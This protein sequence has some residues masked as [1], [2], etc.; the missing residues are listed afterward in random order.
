MSSGISG[1]GEKMGG[2]ASVIADITSEW[3]WM[4]K[5]LPEAYS[6]SASG[7]IDAVKKQWAQDIQSLGNMIKTA[8]PGLFGFIDDLDRRM[9]DPVE[10]PY[11]IMIQGLV[12][13]IKGMGDYLKVAWAKATAL[14]KIDVPDMGK[15]MS[16]ESIES[17][18]D[19]MYAGLNQ[20][21]EKYFDLQK[22][23]IEQDTDLWIKNAVNIARVKNL[24]VSYVLDL[25][26][27]YKEEQNALMEIDK[28][29]FSDRIVDGFKA[30]GIQIK[31]EIKT[32]GERAHEFV[33][34]MAGTLENG[35]MN[36][37]QDMQNWAAQ[38]KATLREIYFEALRLAFFQPAAQGLANAFAGVGSSIVGGLMGGSG[39]NF[40]Q[41]SSPPKAY[42]EGGI[43]WTPQLATVAEKGP[44]LITPLSKIGEMGNVEFHLHND[45]SP[46][47]I[48]NKTQYMMS[49]K[50]IIDVT[51]NAL[52]RSPK[53]RHA[54]SQA[55]G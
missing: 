54:M 20:R 10:N 49:D 34:G 23:R 30:A 48:T 14:P 41:I 19:K 44:E 6:E 16:D 22:K 38:F 45:G 47:E 11:A 8:V 42:A 46:M 40:N 43:A 33:M 17:A 9:Q 25:I 24:E 1:I 7:L 4:A 36:M 5:A 52:G 31:R 55:K 35:F 32:W 2:A 3:V 28:L 51:I 12:D 18:I 15:I 29:K 39:Y 53:L 50:R 13:K 26:A 27:A 21:S 37:A